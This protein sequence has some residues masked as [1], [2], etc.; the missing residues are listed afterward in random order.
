[1]APVI[2]RDFE[3]F[4][5]LKMFSILSYITASLVCISLLTKAEKGTKL[6]F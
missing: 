1:M 3:S 6:H 5:I 4:C 2:Y